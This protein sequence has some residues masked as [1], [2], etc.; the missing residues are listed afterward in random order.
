LST[1]FLFFPGLVGE[2]HLKNELY[3]AFHRTKRGWASPDHE[4]QQTPVTAPWPQPKKKT[5]KIQKPQKKT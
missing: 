3:R 5:K 2:I 1:P 4:K